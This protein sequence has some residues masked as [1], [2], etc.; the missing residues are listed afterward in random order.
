VADVAS[1]REVK[2]KVADVAGHTAKAGVEAARHGVEAA[3]TTAVGFWRG[4]TFPFRGAAFVYFRRPGLIRFWGIPVL[5]TLVL[6]CLVTWGALAMRQPLVDLLWATPTGEGFWASVGRF[7]HVVLE[8]I[9]ALLALLAG[10]VLLSLCSNVIAAPFNDALS[11]A[12]ERFVTGKPPVPFSFTV[13]VRDALRTVLL[14]L[15]KLGTYLAV[16][17]PLF[18]LS[19][20]VPVVGPFLY[21]LFGFFFT[22]GYFAIDYIDWPASRRDRGIRQRFA[23][24]RRHWW[25]MLGFGTGVWLFLFLPLVN[26]LFMPAAVAGG[27][28]LYLELDPEEPP[29][30]PPFPSPSQPSVSGAFTTTDASSASSAGA[31]FEGAEAPPLS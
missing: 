24:L 12:V 15:T 25:P 16:M 28:L 4:F 1:L 3:R 13:V 30:A 17:G 10:L 2:D 31:R 27:T 14:E 22:A 19:W 11:E 18:V 26:L 6:G 8:W 23:V 7:L 29:R 20:L 5:L 21:Y 9:A